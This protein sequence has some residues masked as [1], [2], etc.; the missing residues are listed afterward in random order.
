[1]DRLGGTNLCWLLD[2]VS[3]APLANRDG[4]IGPIVSLRAIAAELAVVGRT[5]LQRDW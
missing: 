4:A 5:A 2:I 3:P 1:M